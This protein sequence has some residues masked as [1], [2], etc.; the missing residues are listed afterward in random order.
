MIPKIIHQTWKGKELPDDLNHWHTRIKELHPG[1]EIRLW[2]D[3]DNLK[4]VQEYFPEVMD[5][6]NNVEYNIMRVD[7]VRYL[8]MAVYGGFYLDLDYELFEPFDDV[9][10]TT[11]LLLPIARDEHQ[12]IV[13]GNCIF[14][15][16]PNHV[17]WSDVILDLKNNPPVNKFYNKH[18]ILKLTGPEFLSRVYFNNPGKYN[19]VLP[20]LK[21]YHPRSELTKSKNYKSTLMA[22]GTKGIHHCAGTWIP[23]QNPLVYMAS[24]FH[25][26]LFKFS[27]KLG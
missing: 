14:G 7:I 6:Y 17:F 24:K 1:W 18:K 16:A 20:P 19:A 4:F 10:S 5:I 13:V 22:Q 25:S 8:Y 3:E 26:L 21:T 2:T 23:S 27:K 12:R 9:V 11:S 15:S